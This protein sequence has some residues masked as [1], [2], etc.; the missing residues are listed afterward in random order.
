MINA[1]LVKQRPILFSGSMVR[2]IL[3]GQKTQTRRVLKQS[4]EFEF[5]RVKDKCPYGQAGDLLWIRETWR[6]ALSESHECVAYRADMRCSCGK[7]MPQP[8]CNT[9][10][11][12][13]IFMPRT[14]ARIFLEITE[15]RLEKLQDISE[16]DAIAE[17]I[18]DCCID[19][20]QW[21]LYGKK[22]IYNGIT[23]EPVTSYSTLWD[24]INGDRRPWQSNP[25][26]WV[27]EFRKTSSPQTKTD[28]IAA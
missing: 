3:A 10:W 6:P 17:G 2:A 22:G 5:L 24:S 20:E 21:Q 8:D 28:A 13:S 23:R 16:S 12:P 4:V 15:I 26:V 18:T 9:R 19:S 25:F 11:K 1:A 27:V 7:E 14:A